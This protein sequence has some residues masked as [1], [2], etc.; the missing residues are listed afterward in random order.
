LALAVLLA[1]G[2]PLA[3]SDPAEPASPAPSARA[4][5]G[6]SEEAL[7]LA[8]ALP[9][10]AGGRV[11]PLLTLA[12]YT[13]LALN[14]RK[15][16]K[17]IEGGEERWIGPTEWLL[18]VLFF[19]EVAAHYR[20]FLVQDDAALDA[21]GF[22]REMRELTVLA[23]YARDRGGAQTRKKRDRWSLAELAP[24]LGRLRDQ[25]SLY[26]DKP[27]GER[28]RVEAQVIVLAENLARYHQL[29]GSL[30]LATGRL[31]VP[32]SPAL[33][34]ILGP[35]TEASFTHV[36]RHLDELLRLLPPP[37]PPGQEP[38]ALTPEQ[39]PVA[40]LLEDLVDLGGGSGALALL[41]PVEGVVGAEP[42]AWLNPNAA[43]LAAQHAGQVPATTLGLLEA[44]ERLGSVLDRPDESLRALRTLSTD[45][46]GAAEARGDYEHVAL[47][48]TYQRLDPVS[49]SWKIYFAGL[50]CALLGLLSLRGGRAGRSL[51]PLAWVLTGGAAA[52]LVAG[53]V[54]RCIIRERPPVTTLYETILFIT[55]TGT[56]ACFVIEALSRRWIALPVAGTIGT[57]GLLLAQWF[58]GLN[59]QDTMPTLEAVLDT[60][61]W[62]STHVT[63]ITFGYSAGLLAAL[64]GMVYVLG[65][66]FGLGKE[67][68]ETYA[69]IGR[70]VYGV[71]G[72]GLLL[73]IVGTILGGIWANDSWGRFWGWDPKENG[74]LMICL[75]ELIM[76]H[77]RMGGYVGQFGFS[78]LAVVGGAVVSWSWW[79]VNQLGVGLHSYGFTEGIQTMLTSIYLTLGGVLVLGLGWWFLKGPGST[80]RP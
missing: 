7:E 38:P 54:M 35:A 69:A 52:V 12:G 65:R 17:V 49:L 48:V 21:I 15:S 25:A 47:E 50:A 19:P 5:P 46:V 18:D 71:I 67:A 32:K 23:S 79:G 33:E 37:A 78:M 26:F 27:A 75:W 36:A 60:N 31:A 55:A 16:V 64:V 58:E 73:S 61:F 13:L 1:G 34:R 53:I 39:E 8:E 41:P 56:L 24:F 80:R 9:V 66:V 14:G 22:T 11:K 45:L 70:T 74:A 2:S 42:G 57:L 30:A 4:H 10:Q 43:L 28:S 20:S 59:K 3:A 29:T 51:R 62:L 63:C 77:A 44:F 76:L 72:F 40:R 6:W 68:H